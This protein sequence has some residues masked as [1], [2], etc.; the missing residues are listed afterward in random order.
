MYSLAK[1]K[2][3]SVCQIEFRS[4]Q[5]KKATVPWCL[6]FGWFLLIQLEHSDTFKYF[7]RFP[8]CGTSEAPN[9]YGLSV[10]G[11]LGSQTSNRWFVTTATTVTSPGEKGASW[12][13]MKP[14]PVSLCL[15]RGL[16]STGKTGPDWSRRSEPV[17]DLIG[18][19]GPLDLPQMSGKDENHQFHRGWGGDWK[20]PQASWVVG[21]EGATSS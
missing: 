12:T 3:D 16:R 20:D 9:L 10:P 5:F 11:S 4:G 14:Y 7:L 2:F 19:G 18:E 8:F 13:W 1:R 17:P 15:R 6:D 21:D